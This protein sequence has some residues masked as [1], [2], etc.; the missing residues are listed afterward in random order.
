MKNKRTAIRAIKCLLA[1]AIALPSLAIAGLCQLPKE[2]KI[3]TWGFE[4]SV[5]SSTPTWSPK[6]SAAE[7]Y[8][9]QIQYSSAKKSPFM[10]AGTP[11]S[12]GF[13]SH[14]LDFVIE[15]KR[16]YTKT[17]DGRWCGV[18]VGI[19]FKVIHQ[20]EIR[21]AKEMQERSCVAKTAM[22]HQLKHHQATIDALKEFKSAAARF[23]QEAFE[24]YKSFGAAGADVQ[25][26]NQS[27]EALDM[28]AKKKI[29]GTFMEFLR[30]ERAKIDNKADI[31]ELQLACNGQ[32]G[33]TAS[34]AK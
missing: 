34:L 1:A 18:V 19:K 3:D 2:Q 8:K 29:A 10:K 32:F 26:I 16:D 25:E 4:I 21:L 13:Y 33:V 12:L 28:E 24:E 5:E 23:K 17:V 20:G 27:S 15:E 7:L 31:A 14:G 22:A 6:N 30:V 11:P 9:E